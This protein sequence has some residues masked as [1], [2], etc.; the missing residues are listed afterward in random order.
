M[1]S[2]F[3]LNIHSVANLERQIVSPLKELWCL[4]NH[5]IPVLQFIKQAIWVGLNFYKCVKGISSKIPH[6]AVKIKQDDG[7]RVCLCAQ[8]IVVF[9]HCHFCLFATPQTVAYQGFLSFNIFWN[10][11]KLKSIEL[12]MPSNHLI[13]YHPFFS[14][15]QFVPSFG[16]FP[17]S[18]LFISSGQSIGASA[19]ASVLPMNIQE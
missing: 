3:S 17:V 19:T 8:Y 7:C 6:F 12:V 10:L 18:Q 5:Q 13:L 16:S 2:G 1:N 4:T 9:R 14:C 11:L 15:P